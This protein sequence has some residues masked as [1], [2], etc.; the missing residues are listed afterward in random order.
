MADQ[1]AEQ[2]TSESFKR[3]RRRIAP[4]A[5]PGSVVVDPSAPKPRIQVFRYGPDKLSESHIE[6][7]AELPELLNRE[8][9]VWV[10]VDG[11]GDANVLRSL[12][13]IFQLHPLAL[14]DVVHVHQRAKVEAYENH[15]FVVMRMITLGEELTTEQLS[16]FIGRDF[17]LTFQEIP[18]DCLEPVRDRLRKNDGRIRRSGPDYLAYCLLDAVI[19]NYFPVLEAY[20][21]RLD[22]LDDMLTETMPKEAVGAIHNIRGDL[23]ELRRAAWP[24]REAINAL[25]RD[26]HSF[27]ANET[28]I[29]L[30]DCYDHTVQIID[31]I[32]I[33]RDTCTDLRDYYYSKVNQRTN[34]VMKTLTIVSTIFIPLSFIA[35]VYGMNFEHMPE[36]KWLY[37]YEFALSLMAIIGGGLVT[38]I[39]RRGWFGN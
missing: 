15:L 6:D 19:D 25:V 18:G 36:I 12:G 22:E 8:G 38:Y 33:F 17:V 39:W 13:E 10:D 37:G 34:D 9:I 20:G 16:V 30:R 11:L 35:S 1:P 24:H 21:E 3:F 2:P 7:P 5:P 4:G 29:Y 28:R 32:E 14:E 31:M 26:A 27:I 23:L